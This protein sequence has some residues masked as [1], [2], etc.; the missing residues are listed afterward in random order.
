MPAK[1]SE[2][3]K[4]EVVMR[5]SYG[6]LCRK[7]ASRLIWRALADQFGTNHTLLRKAH[8][9]GILKA[10]IEALVSAKEILLREASKH[11]VH[12]IAMELGMSTQT[13]HVYCEE[14]GIKPP[15]RSRDE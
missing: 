7:A 8:V 10:E 14:A 15:L 13:I 9:A 11:K 6:M 12:L 5:R 2:A 1:R 4:K 3:D